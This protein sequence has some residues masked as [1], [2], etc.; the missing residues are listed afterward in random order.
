MNNRVSA[1]AFKIKKVKGHDL[2][3]LKAYLYQ[4]LDSGFGLSEDYK[5]GFDALGK[6]I[7]ELDFN[8]IK[9]IFQNVYFDIEQT[10]FYYFEDKMLAYLDYLKGYNTSKTD[11]YRKFPNLFTKIE[12]VS[13]DQGGLIV[14]E[15]YGMQIS[16]LY[17]AAGKHI[18]GPCHDLDLLD[19]NRFLYRSSESSLGFVLDEYQLNAY[20]KTLNT[21][22]DCDMPF[23]PNIGGRDRLAIP[24]YHL[25][26]ERI[27]NFKVPQNKM[28]V[29]NILDDL[30]TNWYTSPELHKFYWNDK[31]LALK[32]VKKDMLAY[33]LLDSQLKEDKEIVLALVKENGIALEFTSEPFKADKSIVLTAVTQNGYALEFA[34]PELKADKE[35]VMAAV[36]QEDFVIRFASEELKTDS[37]IINSTKRDYKF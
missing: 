21:Y 31:D 8:D 29:S 3:F 20:P 30:N 18:E 14:F 2:F 25:P 24:Y 36:T 11:A 15:C 17:T 35:I 5:I 23:C 9:S 12:Q 28:D 26:A 34:S 37:D 1:D 33:T 4:A 19:K 7:E 27:E 16:E 6:E 10:D 22:E 13:F 32:A